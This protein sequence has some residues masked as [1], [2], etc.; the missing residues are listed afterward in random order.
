M[1]VAVSYQPQALVVG[2]QA[3]NMAASTGTPVARE[4]TERPAYGGPYTITPSKEEQTFSTK[5]LRMT[6]NI[7]IE[8]IPSNYG[9]ITWNGTTLI[10]S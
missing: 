6:D 1:K 2:I 7:V 10:V 3:K 9:L 5:D 8:P 4:Y